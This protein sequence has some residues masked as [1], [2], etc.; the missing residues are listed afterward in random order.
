MPFR[1]L[2]GGFSLSGSLG[3]QV[4]ILLSRIETGA[5]LVAEGTVTYDDGVGIVFLQIFQQLAHGLF[6]LWRPRVGRVAVC[7]QPTFIAQPSIYQ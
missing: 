3:L 5:G 1:I 2:Q 7:I 4:L 6:L